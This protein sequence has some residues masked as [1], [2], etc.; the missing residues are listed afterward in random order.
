MGLVWTARS[1][2]PH[3]HGKTW[4]PFSTQ[5]GPPALA[6]VRSLGSRGRAR[7]G[8]ISHQPFFLPLDFSKY[9]GRFAR[10]PRP[11]ATSIF[12]CNW[13]AD[14]LS[15]NDF[16]HV[17]PTSD[18]LA[19]CLARLR[20]HFFTNGTRDAAHASGRLRKYCSKTGTA[21]HVVAFRRKFPWGV[22]PRFG[23]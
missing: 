2:S 8:S 5:M 18:M 6:F 19:Y 11:A 3:R 16:T 4:S 23:R 15:S 17:A 10:C 7:A 21:R 9:C 13:L 20:E 22:A 1:M 14:S 12:F